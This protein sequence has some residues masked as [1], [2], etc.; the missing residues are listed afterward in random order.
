MYRTIENSKLCP[1]E[2]LAYFRA[3]SKEERRFMTVTK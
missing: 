2:K 3:L 1:E